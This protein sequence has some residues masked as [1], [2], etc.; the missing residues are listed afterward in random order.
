MSLIQHSS[1]IGN[2]EDGYHCILYRRGYVERVG[3]LYH[4]KGR[5]SMLTL[6]VSISYQEAAEI[7]EL[8]RTYAEDIARQLAEVMSKYNRGFK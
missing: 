5:G 3:N 7:T 1:T 4:K 2:E 6:E 8:L